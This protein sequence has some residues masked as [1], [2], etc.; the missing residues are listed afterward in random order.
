MK[1]NLVRLLPNCYIVYT[2]SGWTK[3]LRRLDCYKNRNYRFYVRQHTLNDDAFFTEIEEGEERQYNKNY[4][5]KYPCVVSWQD[6]TFEQ[7]TYYI[8][9]RY[10][11]KDLKFTDIET[12]D[13]DAWKK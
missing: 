7:N 6:E 13:T 9:I 8:Y 3:L 5:I 12:I 2:Q 11:T 1:D 4:P 10:I